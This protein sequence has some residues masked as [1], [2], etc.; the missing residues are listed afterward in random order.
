MLASGKRPQE[1]KDS[2]IRIKVGE[3][4]THGPNRWLSE[5]V[6]SEEKTTTLSV[7]SSADAIVG[8]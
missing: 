2:L 8:K 6:N 5:V 1:S 7:T 3:A 4:K